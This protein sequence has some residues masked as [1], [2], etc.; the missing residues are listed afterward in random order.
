MTIVFYYPLFVPRSPLSV[1]FS[2]NQSSYTFDMKDINTSKVE[3]AVCII[4]LDRIISIQIILYVFLM[5]IICR[6]FLLT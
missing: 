1:I 4:F 6:I 3:Q 2:Y 5:F